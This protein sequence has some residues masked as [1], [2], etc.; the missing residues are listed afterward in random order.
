MK[1]HHI[2]IATH[3]IDSV[4]L[5][6]Q[7]LGYSIGEL[8]QDTKRNV[9]IC[10]IK[11]GD[12]TLELVEPLSDNSPVS[13][14]LKNSVQDSLYHICYSVE[15]IEKTIE[16]LEKQGYLKISSLDFAPAIHNR[17]VVFMFEKD[18]GLIE[19]VED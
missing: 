19:L 4:L 17:R 13:A 2:A 14:I 1:M 15:N 8:I 5:K 7:Y 12:F 9:Q 16:N 6:Y 10:F 3:C 18:L 11:N